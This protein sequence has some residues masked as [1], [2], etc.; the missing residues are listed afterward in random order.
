MAFNG[1]LF[2]L[3]TESDTLRPTVGVVAASATTQVTL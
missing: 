1:Y 3:G 2:D